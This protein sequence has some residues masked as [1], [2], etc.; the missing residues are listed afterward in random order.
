MVVLLP[1]SLAPDVERGSP[2]DFEGG[3]GRVVEFRNAI[4]YPAEARRRYG[5][6]VSVP[7]VA[8]V[9]SASATAG[10]GSASVLVESEPALVA[11]VPGL[12]ALFGDD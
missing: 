5:V 12:E 9:T 3:E 1:A 11:L 6:E 4:V 7:S 2:V 8:V 10:A